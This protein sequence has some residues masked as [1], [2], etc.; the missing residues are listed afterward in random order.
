M[1]LQVVG[2]AA[3]CRVYC[4]WLVLREG[5][6]GMREGERKRERKRGKLERGKERQCE[7]K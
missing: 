1:G 2:T 5:R 3:L 4:G 6:V 7:G